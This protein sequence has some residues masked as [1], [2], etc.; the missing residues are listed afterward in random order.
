VVL[1]ELER[2]LARPHALRRRGSL[3]MQ[4][5]KAIEVF[6]MRYYRWALG[7]F[8]R[9]IQEGFPLLR[10]IKGR[11]SLRLLAAMEPLQRDEQMR[12]STAL[13]KRFHPQAMTITGEGLTAEEDELLQRYVDSILVP[14]KEEREIDRQVQAGTLRLSLNKK[15]FVTL[16]NRELQM[17]LG[18]P[19]QVQGS[20]ELW[21]ATRIGN[22]NVQTNINV[23]G[24]YLY[25]LDYHH[26]IGT[27][28]HSCYLAQWATFL[29][30]LGVSSQ[31]T[32]D[33]LTQ[34]DV[35]EAVETLALL[36]SHF[37][38]AAPRLL[39]DLILD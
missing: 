8:H 22:W 11:S 19:S 20:R 29:S 12:F 10:R 6:A 39:E 26:R 9:E 38:Q 35:P 17:V 3:N 36:C 23:S 7:D 13:V 2:V 21:Y 37:M 25:Q 30:W 18:S 14:A 32:W 34:S 33:L 24:R 16:I 28:D 4:T 5:H 15:E 27:T 1:S 31:T